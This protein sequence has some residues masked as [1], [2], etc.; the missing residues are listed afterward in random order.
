MNS[1]YSQ[2]AAGA[3]IPS[4]RRIEPDT[5]V[6]ASAASMSS[7]GCGGGSPAS[8]GLPQQA[9]RA[10]WSQDRL[11]GRPRGRGDMRGELFIVFS[12]FGGAE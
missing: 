1:K 9:D 8:R 10:R 11:R 7:R 5:R 4:R 3:M 2:P 12:L 6:R